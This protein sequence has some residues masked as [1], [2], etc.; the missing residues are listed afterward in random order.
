MTVLAFIKEN[1]VLVAGLVLPLLLAGILAFAKAL[2]ARMVDP[3]Q[4]KPVYFSMDWCARDYF[5]IQ[6][7]DKGKIEIQSRKN[8]PP[9]QSANFSGYACGTNG[10]VPKL[11]VYIYTPATNHVQ[12]ITLNLDSPDKIPSLDMLKTLT[13]SA[14]QTAPDG[15]IFSSYETRNYSLITDIFSSHSYHHGPVLTKDGRTLRLPLPKATY[16]SIDFLGWVIEGE[17]K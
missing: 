14:Q 15:Y 12:D 11:I 1:R 2:P 6:I 9:A 10:T 5:T 17:A 3:P 8:K 16:G 4:Y 7:G 13:L